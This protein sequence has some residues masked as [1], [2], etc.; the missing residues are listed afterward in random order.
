M[1]LCLP[2]CESA[3]PPGSVVES[4]NTPPPVYPTGQRVAI[5]QKEHT[6]GYLTIDRVDKDTRMIDDVETPA[7]I[8]Y[9]YENTDIDSRLLVTSIQLELTYTASDGQELPC[10]TFAAGEARPETAAKGEAK[11]HQ[12]TYILG[13]GSDYLLKYRHIL[14]EEPFFLFSI[15]F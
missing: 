9:T 1:L 14:T 4:E 8:H 7:T 5:K 12:Q 6:A 10:Q 3:A 15:T 2:G 11:S 13:S